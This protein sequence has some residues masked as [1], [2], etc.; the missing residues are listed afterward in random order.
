MQSA[1]ALPAL[2]ALDWIAVVLTGL[3]GLNLAAFPVLIS[4]VYVDMF[5]EFGAE[6]PGLTRLVIQA[7][8]PA[9][10]LVL[11]VGLAAW[12]LLGRLGLGKRRALVVGAFTLALVWTGLC[13][14][15]LYLP[16]FELAESV[17]A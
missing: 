11:V 1:R 17:K 4:P 3:V 8:F 5:A 9:L 12:G 2:T 14:L 10:G 7:W 13:W 15:G 16:I 6:L